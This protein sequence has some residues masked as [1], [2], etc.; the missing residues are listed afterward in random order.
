MLSKE[1]RDLS[2]DELISQEKNLKEELFNLKFQHSLGQL[3]N[4]AQIR[5]MKR[6]IA[7]IKTILTE[8]KNG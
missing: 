1:I 2:I 7:R 4:T 5:D 6:T 3:Q 8:K